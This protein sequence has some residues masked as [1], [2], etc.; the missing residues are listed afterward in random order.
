MQVVG[1][2]AG[3]R[4]GGSHK[5]LKELVR[6]KLVGYDNKKAEGYRLTTAG[7]DF[8]ALRTLS[9]RES[10]HGVGNQI[11]VGKESGTGS[12]RS[13]LCGS[14]TSLV[15]ASSRPTPANPT[16]TTHPTC[17]V[18]QCYCLRRGQGSHSLHHIDPKRNPP[19]GSPVSNH[20]P[21]FFL[22]F[23]CPPPRRPNPR[24]H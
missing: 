5:V 18:G 21:F 24:R 19:L 22:F 10:L 1:G 14:G 12:R 6:H 13:V 9:N 7:F 2:L 16:N 23:C 4:R 15:H 20:L 8:L 11:G 17:S 3:L